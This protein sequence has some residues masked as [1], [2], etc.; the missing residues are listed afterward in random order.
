MEHEA[1]K[2]K[3]IDTIVKD[4]RN[5]VD[6]NDDFYLDSIGFFDFSLQEQKEIIREATMEIRRSY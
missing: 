6:V 3:C 5:R 1:E 2:R 4:Y